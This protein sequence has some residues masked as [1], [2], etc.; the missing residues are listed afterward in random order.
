MHFLVI[1]GIDFFLTLG[2]MG[3]EKKFLEVVIAAPFSDRICFLY[4]CH[5]EAKL[6]KYSAKVQS[7]HKLALL[8]VKWPNKRLIPSKTHIQASTLAE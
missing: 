5:I 4:K 7:V 3:L 6:V 1:S 8:G 2:G